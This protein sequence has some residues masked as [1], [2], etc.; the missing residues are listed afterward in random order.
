MNPPT[1]PPV[2]ATCQDTPQ[3]SPKPDKSG[4]TADP[5][6]AGLCRPKLDVVAPEGQ[7]KGN[8]GGG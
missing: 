2:A 3:Q 1:L 8:A 6:S 4:D 5:P 7:E